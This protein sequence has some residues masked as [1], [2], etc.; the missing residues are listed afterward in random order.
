MANKRLDPRDRR[1]TVSLALPRGL[2]DAVDRMAAEQGLS[3]SWIIASHLEHLRA[4]EE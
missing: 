4:T 3:R 1:V 2:I